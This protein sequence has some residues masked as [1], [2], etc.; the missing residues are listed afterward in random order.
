MSV[1]RIHMTNVFCKTH[2]VC[3]SWNARLGIIRVVGYCI[4]G[5]ST[6]PWPVSLSWSNWE[7]LACRLPRRFPGRWQSSAGS[8]TNRA[9]P[10]STSGSSSRLAD[11]KITSGRR[12]LRIRASARA[13]ALFRSL[14]RTLPAPF[15]GAEAGGSFFC[16]E[17]EIEETTTLVKSTLKLDVLQRL[18]SV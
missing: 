2:K 1:F 9:S 7:V 8:S 16:P 3:S 15:E 12:C 13:P 10:P 11:C 6:L 18:V 14:S 5:R 4:L 17:A